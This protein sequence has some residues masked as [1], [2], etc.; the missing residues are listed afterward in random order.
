MIKHNEGH[1]DL[2]KGYIEEGE[3][4]VEAAIREVKEETNIDV[5]V[6]GNYRYMTGYS[7][8]EGV[9]KK[10]VYYIATKKSNNLIPQ[11]EEVHIY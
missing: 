4:E 1:L 9:W 5:E 6:Y 7:P 2:P 3:T 10:I 11:Q 8:M